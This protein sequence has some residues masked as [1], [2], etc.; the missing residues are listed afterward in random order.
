MQWNNGPSARS[1]IDGSR[2][3]SAVSCPTRSLCVAVDQAG[4]VLIG[5]P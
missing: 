1:D 3:L 5:K 2:E 4:Y